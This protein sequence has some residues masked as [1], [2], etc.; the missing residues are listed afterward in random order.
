[1]NL[2]SKYTNDFVVCVDCSWLIF[3][4]GASLISIY[5][6]RIID[7]PHDPH[8]HHFDPKININFES[9]IA[10]IMP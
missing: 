6:R 7:M 4:N 5:E 8:V 10:R 3:G 9:R 2:C 1:M